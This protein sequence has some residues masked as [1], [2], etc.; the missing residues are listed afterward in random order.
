MVTNIP[1]NAPVVYVSFSAEIDTKTTESLIAVMSNCV[2]SKVQSVYLLLS[3]PGGSV[4]CGLN[5]YN[6]LKGMPFE[7]I[8][9][10]VA[11]VDSI[12]NAVFLAGSRRY[13]TPSATFMFHGVGFNL[14]QNER[15]E[16]KQLRE[17]LDG[18]LSNQQR[19][20][21]IISQRTT[22][23]ETEIE[24]LFR[25]AQTKDATYAINKGI[26]HEI[27]DVQI[28]AGSTMLSL[29]FQR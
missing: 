12:G 1:Q 16:E 13:A 5:L 14:Q 19:I 26:V 9:H 24:A 29:V 15:Y 23:S 17:R 22:L 18:V 20:G 8:T 4:M 21:Q 10:N 3:T 27:R 6:V 7:L 25:E 11:N 2:N 28:P